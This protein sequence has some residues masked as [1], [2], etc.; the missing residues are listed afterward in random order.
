MKAANVDETCIDKHG[1]TFGS[2]SMNVRCYYLCSLLVSSGNLPQI[3]KGKEAFAASVWKH[4]QDNVGGTVRNRGLLLYYWC[5]AM[6][7]NAMLQPYDTMDYF[8]Q[9]S[10]KVRAFTAEEFKFGCSNSNRAGST[11][12]PSVTSPGAGPKP[13]QECAVYDGEL[14]AKSAQG[15]HRLYPHPKTIDHIARRTI[16]RG[17][18]VQSVIWAIQGMRGLFSG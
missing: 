16:F 13:L 15:R 18:T 9:A 7:D 6:L 14:S 1:P 8:P 17:A 11:W 10:I 4:M 3:K 2:P 5:M 12:A